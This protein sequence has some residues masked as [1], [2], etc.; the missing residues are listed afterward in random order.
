MQTKLFHSS[1]EFCKLC[2]H[3]NLFSNLFPFY[4]NNTYSFI[5]LSNFIKL[6]YCSLKT[7]WHRERERERERERDTEIHK[8]ISDVISQEFILWHTYKKRD[9]QK[10]TYLLKITLIHRWKQKKKNK[11]K[12]ATTN[13]VHRSRIKGLP[14]FPFA[15]SKNFTLACTWITFIVF[16]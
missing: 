6:V 15:S 8:H 1:S 11:K 9:T 7:V 13:I 5:S 3:D 16:L 4:Y 12:H 2:I 14:L 10:Y